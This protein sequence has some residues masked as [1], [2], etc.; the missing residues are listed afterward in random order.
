M[1][2]IVALC[3]QQQAFLDAHGGWFDARVQAGKII[4]GHGDLRPEHV[5][6]A[7]RL[8]VIDCLEF[9]RTL[10]TGDPA[11]ELAYL[12]LECERLQADGPGRLL[13][14]C[15]T[16]LT[17][18]HPPAALVHFYQ[19]YRAVLRAGIAIRHLDEQQFRHSPEW[20]RR[21]L[22]Y[23]HLARRHQLSMS[24]DTEAPR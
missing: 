15:Y 13:L 19:A 23:L 4:E 11:D 20:R 8:W 1:A 21:A 22:D 16:E 24:A 18:D 9:S 3:A 5:C 6:L 2:D 7:P 10:R 17:G 12:A 14:P